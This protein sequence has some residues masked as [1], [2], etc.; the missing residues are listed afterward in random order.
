MLGFLKFEYDIPTCVPFV[1]VFIFHLSYL[2][3]SEISRSVLSCLMLI[4][5]NSEPYCLK[6]FFFSCLSSPSKIPIVCL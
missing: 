3:F 2:V 1:S 6:Y 4:W 5:E